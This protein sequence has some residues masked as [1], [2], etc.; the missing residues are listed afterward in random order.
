M[1][2]LLLSESAT[3]PEI[4]TTRSR[5]TFY[6]QATRWE[7]QESTATFCLDFSI[8]KGVSEAL[9]DRCKQVLLWYAENLSMPHTM[10][11][12]RRLEHFFRVI[13]KG[14]SELIDVISSQ[15]IINYRVSLD[16]RHQWY[17]GSLSGFLKKWDALGYSG[18]SNDV[19]PLLKQLRIQG[20]WKGEAILT[21][22]PERGA[23]TDIE[24]EAIYS[25]LDSAKKA[26][27]ISIEYYL[28]IFLYLLLGQ[29]PT[30]YAALKVCDVSVIS[31]KDGQQSYMLRMPRA[32]QRESLSRTEFKNRLITPQIGSLLVEYANQIRDR[33]V[34]QLAD[35]S[36]APL[37]PAKRAR[38]TGFSGFEFH[39]TA[40]ALTR[41]MEKELSALQ[42][43][44]ERT[45]RALKMNPVRFRRTVGT[46][47]ATEGHGELIIA[48]LLDH[49]DTQ[50]VG[51]YIEATPGMVERID[52]AIAL[53]LAP[54]AQAFQ[55]MIITDESKAV[56]ASDPQSRICAP[57]IVDSMEPMGNCGKFG[58][59][60]A[61]APIA[62]Y[63][64]SNFQ[65]WLD[66]PHEAVLSSL[67]AERDRL[68]VDSDIRIASVNDRTILAVAQVVRRCDDIKRE[69]GEVL[70][71]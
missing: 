55:G 70:H 27:H 16:A 8:L 61:F 37:F 49:S 17:L 20:N 43:F 58:F 68:L 4:A 47:A 3:L 28:L 69:A 54:M 65:P 62:C 22:D 71:D 31:G 56:R 32:K 64:C 15:D 66:G 67:I 50:N 25:A 7:I 40:G 6:P 9:R 42:V 23:F 39:R 13:T 57:Q 24:V 10:N 60:G 63:T 52:K 48:E 59:C 44:S 18:I 2:N 34:G 11:L 53:Q 45:G 1:N 21:A 19:V 26:G 41:S 29:R 12:F 46:R 33:F 38:K 51:V 5:F 30:Q 35:P 14:H 36:Q